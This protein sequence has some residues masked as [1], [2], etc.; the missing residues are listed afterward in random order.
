MAHTTVTQAIDI[1]ASP[2]AVWD[3][4]IDRERG[5]VWRNAD[6]DTDWQA[7]SPI[8]IS[9]QIGPK[10]YR[11][12]G[13][14]LAVEEPVRLVYTFWPRVSG[15]PDSPENYSVVTLQLVPQLAATT[16]KVAH[17][18]PPSPPRRGK[19]FEIGPESGWK[20]VEFYWRTTLPLLRDLIEGRDSPALR[21][22]RLNARAD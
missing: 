4:L 18:V 12:K 13:T 3:A 14:V 10:R 19:G 8:A 5:L 6:Y 15:L 17:S 22:A 2:Q 9:A 20:H 11:D 21:I 1:A 16:L 7:G